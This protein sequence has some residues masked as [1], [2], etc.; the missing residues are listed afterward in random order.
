[1]WALPSL[2]RLFPAL[3]PRV[4]L[5]FEL[6]K[7]E[8]AEKFCWW[9]WAL[10]KQPPVML[11][12]KCPELER[13]MTYP[14]EAV[15]KAFGPYFTSSIAFM[16]AFAIGRN[17]EEISI[18][19]VDMMEGAEYF[20]QRPCVEYLL[21][22]ALGRGIKIHIPNVSSLLKAPYTYGYDFKAHKKV[23]TNEERLMDELALHKARAINYKKRLASLG[24]STELRVVTGEELAQTGALGG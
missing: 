17:A 2:H 21:G 10:E 9:R 8:H 20:Y 7:K 5:W 14:R 11:Q 16:L 19:G 3:S 1:M 13:S 4:N 18:Y 23:P 6:H 15:E 24:E 22:I 12:E